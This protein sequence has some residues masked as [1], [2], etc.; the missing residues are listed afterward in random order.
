MCGRS[1]VNRVVLGGLYSCGK[2]FMEPSTQHFFD[3]FNTISNVML[4]FGH[5]CKKHPVWFA[6]LGAL[7]CNAMHLWPYGTRRRASVSSK[8]TTILCTLERPPAE[9]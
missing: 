8:A 4:Y 6:A 9:R 1:S 3:L 2:A 7:A 5:E